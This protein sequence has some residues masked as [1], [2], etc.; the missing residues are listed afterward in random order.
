VNRAPH[1]A[2]VHA[3]TAVVAITTE[4]FAEHFPEASLRHLLDSSLNDE[5]DGNPA[6][7]AK[8]ERRLTAQL[9]AALATKPWCVLTTCSSYPTTV[10]TYAATRANGTPV[11]RPD[12]AMIE[13]IGQASLERL[14]ILATLDDAAQAVEFNLGRAD[15]A[16]PASV[17]ARVVAR[18]E[19]DFLEL[20]LEAGRALA[21]EDGV[22][23]LALAQYSLAPYAEMIAQAAGVPVYSGPD[24][25]ARALRAR[26]LA[27]V[28][29]GLVAV[30]A[31]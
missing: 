9:D 30:D 8:L 14:G 23:G 27:Q 26:L 13:A 5:L 31:T 2:V 10:D 24:A 16:L 4:A 17:T 19:P 3:N 18:D 15:G 21:L 12:A 6:T 25:A 20:L 28:G 29:D 1:I 22:D 11:L 7:H